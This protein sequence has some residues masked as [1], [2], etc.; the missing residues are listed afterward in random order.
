M[1]TSDQVEDV[2]SRFL[3]ARDT[4]S[5]LTLEDLC[6]GNPD[7]LSQVRRRVQAAD[8]L[9]L[10][11]T[12][13]R[14]SGDTASFQQSQSSISSSE[15]PAALGGFKVNRLLGEGGMGCVL[16]AEDETL[17]R[18]VAVKV[19]KGRLAAD[20]LARERFLREARAVAAI[21][22]DHVVPIYHV[23]EHEGTPFIVMPL[24]QGESLASR[25]DRGPLSPSEVA[26][27]GREA[28]LGLAAAH[29][30]GLV[31]RDI[32][33]A[34]LWLEAANG[35][36]LVL[37]F[38]LAQPSTSAQTLTQPGLV[39]G[40]PYYM[41][42]EQLEGRSLDGRSDLFSLGV[43]LYE[44]ATG[45]RPFGGTLTAVIRAISSEMPRPPREMN[46]AIS[47]SFSDF[48]M[49]LLAKSPADRPASAEVMAG[50]LDRISGPSTDIALIVDRSAS[51]SRG[52]RAMFV[53][54]GGVLLLLVGVILWL[55]TRPR[56][57]Q[58]ETDTASTGSETLISTSTPSAAQAINAAA[59]EP[60]RVISLDVQ[61]IEKIGPELG[62][63]R[64]VLLGTVL[65]VPRIDDQIRL[66]ARLSRPAYGY[67]IG[68]RPDGKVDLLSKN[69]PDQKTDRLRYPGAVRA[70]E[71]DVRYALSDGTGLYVFA[72]LASDSPL[73]SFDEV[74]G[75]SNWTPPPTPAGEVYQ[76]DG[77]SIE[78]LA[79][80]TG[81]VRGER[82]PGAK[83]LGGSR[84]VVRAGSELRKAVT[85]SV[86]MAVGIGVGAR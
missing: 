44:C 81:L 72:V 31:H 42:P 45:M 70:E 46:Q 35:R 77:E 25:M 52:R 17:K 34:N 49:R 4:D 65:V 2:V 53:A 30:A 32:K 61:H 37:D 50:E 59:T 15:L 5:P 3:A 48:I 20:P 47:H 40:T 67:L 60:L 64:G 26:R 24:L 10:L 74:W 54:I 43:V 39:V 41:S 84:G 11:M 29:A 55:S 14:L 6:R 21:R 83:S 58:T 80:A 57:A 56:Q 22:H 63:D 62:V 68:F 69:R 1:V 36:V 7:L 23:G 12:H 86:V 19:M 75:L 27:I 28:A 79:R 9:N 78:T 85:G 16:L 13:S 18:Q 66:D 73:P 82:G 51:R 38:G 8:A 76:Y 71:D 33:P